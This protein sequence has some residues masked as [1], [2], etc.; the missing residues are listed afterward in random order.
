MNCFVQV[1]IK[2]SRS[3]IYVY[4]IAKVPLTAD[5]NPCIINVYTQLRNRFIYSKMKKKEHLQM[6][7]NR[8]VFRTLAAFLAAAMMT[9]LAACGGTEA[10][11]LRVIG[12]EEFVNQIP[13]LLDGLHVVVG[14]AVVR[15]C[16]FLLD[17]S[18]GV[19]SLDYG[20]IIHPQC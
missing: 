15:H 6:K 17:V 12:G 7:D 4:K 9:S 3:S 13:S 8:K 1:E 20:Y 2:Q 10:V 14:H 18:V 5:K 16:R 11:V 19:R